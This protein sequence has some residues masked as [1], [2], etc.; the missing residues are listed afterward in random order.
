MVQTVAN[1]FEVIEVFCLRN[2]IYHAD[3]GGLDMVII[4]PYETFEK[5]RTENGNSEIG[6]IK[7]RAL[8][9]D[10]TY[11]LAQEF[12]MNKSLTS[13]LYS[14]TSYVPKGTEIMTEQGWKSL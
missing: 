14:D 11:Y 6:I 7:A 9:V 8:K 2:G 5:A 3:M 4:T 10:D 13:T 12:T 1:C